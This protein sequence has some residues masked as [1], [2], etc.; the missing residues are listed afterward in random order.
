[1][2]PNQAD[3]EGSVQRNNNMVKMISGVK[4]RRSM[5]DVLILVNNDFVFVFINEVLLVSVGRQ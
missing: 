1:M 2:C 5:S 3:V 4:I